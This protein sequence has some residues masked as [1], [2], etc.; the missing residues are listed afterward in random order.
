MEHCRPEIN[1][2]YSKE[3]IKLI[4]YIKA[5][6]EEEGLF[7]HCYEVLE[8]NSIKLAYEAS[9]SS[10]LGVG[11]SVIK[12]EAVLHIY[13]LKEDQPIY[14]INVDNNEKLKILGTNAARYV[15]RIAFKEL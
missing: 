1:V 6:I 9:K 2:C 12:Q 3:N 4:K 7:A 10:L 11:I 14:I 15:K 13:D 5:G 8:G